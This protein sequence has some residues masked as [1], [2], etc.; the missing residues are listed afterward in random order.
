MLQGF[1][2]GTFV[3]TLLVAVVVAGL[4]FNA[5]TKKRYNETIFGKKVA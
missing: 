3:V 5:T 2:K 1:H 4:I